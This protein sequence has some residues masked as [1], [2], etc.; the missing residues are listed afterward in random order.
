MA[1]EVLLS[2]DYNEKADVSARLAC[3]KAKVGRMRSDSIILRYE[4]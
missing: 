4:C 3:E 1:P 2:E